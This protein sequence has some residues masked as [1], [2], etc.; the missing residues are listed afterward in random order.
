M[1][2]Q[3]SGAL[4]GAYKLGRR[5]ARREAK[6]DAG[7]FCRRGSAWGPGVFSFVEGKRGF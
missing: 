2:R 4:V 1:A 7:L 3:K 5:V 6:P